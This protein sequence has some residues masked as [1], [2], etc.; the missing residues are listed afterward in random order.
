MQTLFGKQ[1]K[2]EGFFSKLKAAVASTKSNLVGRIEEVVKG[3]KE[4]DAALLDD[5]ESILIGADLG[6][7]TTTEVLDKIRSQ[8][9][10]KQVD[11]ASQVK[12]L[13]KAELGHI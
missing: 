4:V 12:S 1:E 8:V 6:V 13:I 3:K 5:L 10:R 7:G 11:D 9:S 2:K